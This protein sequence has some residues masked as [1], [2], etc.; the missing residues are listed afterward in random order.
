METT[1]LYGRLILLPLGPGLIGLILMTSLF[2]GYYT[3]RACC[4]KSTTNILVQSKDS[5]G[6]CSLCSGFF[7]LAFDLFPGI[8]APELIG[9][10]NRPSSVYYCILIMAQN[11]G[12][13]QHTFILLLNLRV[14]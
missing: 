2:D 14:S 7:V 13:K 1:K 11:S 8:L 4:E 5:W 10:P 6:T 12:L 9:K 3:V